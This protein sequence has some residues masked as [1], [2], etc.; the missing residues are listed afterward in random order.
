MALRELESVMA[1]E[2]EAA[3]GNTTINYE[4]E[5]AAVETLVVVVA[6]VDAA[7]A[8][9]AGNRAAVLTLVAAR[10]Q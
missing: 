7:A 4:A 2:T 8:P 9:D 10:Q 1:S 3:S 6:A 5:L